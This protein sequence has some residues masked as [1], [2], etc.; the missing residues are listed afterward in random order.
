MFYILNRTLIIGDFLVSFCIEILKIFLIPLR[1]I[2]KNKSINCI[3]VCQVLDLG[4]IIFTVPLIQNI[5]L[6]FPQ[7]KIILICGSWG[8]ELVR[9]LN[10][11][12]D[13]IVY[14]SLAAKNTQKITLSNIIYLIKHIIVSQADIV[15]NVR[16]DFFT[17][18]GFLLLKF[19]KPYTK[20]YNRISLTLQELLTRQLYR[21][22]IIHQVEKNLMFLKYSKVP[23]K[24]DILQLDVYISKDVFCKFEALSKMKYIVIHLGA[25]FS[26]RIWPSEYTIRFLNLLKN[27]LKGYRFVL[28]GSKKDLLNKNVFAVLNNVKDDE[29][30]NLVGKTS[31][32]ELVYIIKHSKLFIGPDTGALHLAVGLGIPVIG[33]YGPDIPEKVGPYKGKNISTFIYKKLPCSPC[34]QVKCIRP[35]NFC[36]MQ[37][38]PEEVYKIAVELLEESFG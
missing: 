28:T 35:Q 34:R 30:I 22:K 11:V 16:G 1:V 36:V 4:D 18:V 23:I 21:K 7:A 12:D 37:I 31:I 26:Y 10:I 9:M 33:L 24:T 29:V 6:S 2:Y 14:N 25:N 15:Y 38:Q 8:E 13:I 32:A 5:R 20:I 3:V 19:L 17:A 27:T